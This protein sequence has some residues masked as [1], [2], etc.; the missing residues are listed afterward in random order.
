MDELEVAQRIEPARTVESDG[1]PPTPVS[2][3]AGNYWR[4]RSAASKR[5]RRELSLAR[6]GATD[7]YIRNSYYWYDASGAKDQLRVA[8]IR[9]DDEAAGPA[10]FVIVVEHGY[11]T[12]LRRNLHSH[13]D[14]ESITECR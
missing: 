8:Y 4:M 2:E 5:A 1:T 12:H 6:D 7:D 14:L 9:R 13:K 10:Y 3:R 11:T